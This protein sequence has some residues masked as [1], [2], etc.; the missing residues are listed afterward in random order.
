MFCFHRE[1]EVCFSNDTCA[2]LIANRGAGADAAVGAAAG[3]A[4]IVP[5]AAARHEIIRY[6]TVPAYLCT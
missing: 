3:A 2:P 4:S 1:L 5:G 6:G